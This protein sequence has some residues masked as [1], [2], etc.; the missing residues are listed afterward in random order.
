M[1]A[2]LAATSWPD[3]T[4]GIAFLGLCAVCAVVAGVVWT[5]R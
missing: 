3:A 1:T 2:T 4:L 5:R